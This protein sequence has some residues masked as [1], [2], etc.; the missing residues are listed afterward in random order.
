MYGKCV[1]VVASI[2]K[3]LHFF[4]TYLELLSFNV[5]KRDF[6][7]EKRVRSNDR[8]LLYMFYFGYYC[9]N[10]YFVNGLIM[11]M[12]PDILFIHLTVAHISECN[13]QID[14]RI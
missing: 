5:L 8:S 12:F 7:I 14:D 10:M 13:I 1:C 6:V 9:N 4:L 3:H 11:Q 2:L